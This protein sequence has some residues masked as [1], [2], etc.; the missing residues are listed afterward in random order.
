MVHQEWTDAANH[1]SQELRSTGQWTCPCKSC[2]FVRGK[3]L[4][5]AVNGG[6]FVCGAP[7]RNRRSLYCGNAC[8]QQAYR[9]RK[10]KEVMAGLNAKRKALFTKEER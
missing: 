4:A 5:T 7:C 9:W 3:L 2:L 8:K 10:E 6:C 1:A